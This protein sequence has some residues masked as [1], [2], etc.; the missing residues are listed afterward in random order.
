M[1]VERNLNDR[2]LELLS[3]YLDDA[4]SSEER[5]ALDA[6]LAAE[7]ALRRELAA[8][9]QTVALV[10][11]FS[12]ATAPRN[13]TLTAAMVRPPKILFFPATTAVSL[14]SAVA[15]IVLVAAGALLLARP[16]PSNLTTAALPPQTQQVAFA[17]TATTAAPGNNNL[18]AQT[19]AALDKV[20]RDTEVAQGQT[21]ASGP[22][23]ETQ[24]QAG[25]ND[26]LLAGEAT[27]E[28]PVLSYAA[29][30]AMPTLTA[31]AVE[32]Q[33]QEG[34][35]SDLFAAA[36]SA[37]SANPA[38]TVAPAPMAAMIQP[39]G[40]MAAEEPPASSQ[41]AA[42]D[43]SSSANGSAAGGAAAD[44]AIIQQP[45]ETATAT[46]TPTNRPTLTATATATASPTA[47]LVPSV[48]PSPTAAPLIQVSG[49]SSGL[50]GLLLIV[51]GAAA[52]LLALA[53]ALAR[54][55]A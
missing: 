50:V 38:D 7:P 45:S 25:L 27:E 2:D 44:A 9:R 18:A 30:S 24:A 10:H 43:Q 35:D 11:D 34:D 13:F 39:Q 36:S 40:T 55:R 41:L 26:G 53:A 20:T 49:G 15:A 12:R 51:A 42:P 16:N 32:E 29:R 23:E 14:M 8:L 54:R 47:T 19:E 52:L 17:P 5:A 1:S 33:T 21:A 48:T 22:V 31:G 6:R 28:A 4:L 3:A 46:A 37:E